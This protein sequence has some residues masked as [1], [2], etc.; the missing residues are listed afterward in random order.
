MRH[1]SRPRAVSFG[2]AECCELRTFCSSR[3]YIEDG[4]QGDRTGSMA[5]LGTPRQRIQHLLRRAGFGYRAD[6]LEEYVRLG[7][8][9]SVDRLLHPELVDDSALQ[10]TLDALLQPF[11]LDFRD[12]D[13]DMQQ[14]QALFR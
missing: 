12:K 4:S 3:R 2:P 1:H 9:G 8:E 14:R 5:S 6:E 10:P 11:A 7:L 13:A